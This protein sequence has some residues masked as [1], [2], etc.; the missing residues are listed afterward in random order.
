[1]IYSSHSHAIYDLAARV[2]ETETERGSGISLGM[3]G[4]LG[5]FSHITPA[6]SGIIVTNDGH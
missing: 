6:M 3:S 4:I 2:R 1:M 5:S